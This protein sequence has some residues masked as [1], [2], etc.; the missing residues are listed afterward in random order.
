MKVN[1]NGYVIFSTKNVD[2]KKRIFFK[3]MNKKIKLKFLVS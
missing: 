2:E 3:K 1:M